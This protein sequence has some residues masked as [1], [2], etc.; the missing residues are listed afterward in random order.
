M[1]DRHVGAVVVIDDEQRCPADRRRRRSRHRDR[2]RRHRTRRKA[3]T[4][5]D[6]M[7]DG[8]RR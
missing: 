5:G 6:V 3:I 7:L 8:W 4:A 1:R 2:N